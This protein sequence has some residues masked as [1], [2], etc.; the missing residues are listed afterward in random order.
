MTTATELLEVF[1]KAQKADVPYYISLFDDVG[2]Y[3]ISFTVGWQRTKP[4]NMDVFV[5]LWGADSSLDEV[6]AIIDKKLNE[7]E[8]ER[9]KEK[10]RREVLATLTTAQRAIL[11]V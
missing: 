2:I 10:Q 7:D 9:K 5:Y 3:K 4:V 11:G 8:Q 6:A 1:V